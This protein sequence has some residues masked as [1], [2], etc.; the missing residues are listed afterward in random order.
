MSG[1]IDRLRT[2]LLPALV[3]AA[4]VALVTAGLL[5]WAGPTA[6]GAGPPAAPT[7]PSSPDAASASPSSIA[8]ASTA[9]WPSS[10][11]QPSPTTLGVASRVVIP[12]LRVDLPV[13]ASPPN[14]TFPLC[15][16]A[17]YSPQY[18]QPGQPG[19]T[20][21][22]A[23][24]RTGMFLPLLE[25]SWVDNGKAMIGDLVEV[26][27][28]ADRLYLYEISAVDR[29]QSSLP[30]GPTDGGAQGQLMLQTSE[31]PRKGLPGY[32]GLVLV[33]LAKPL[34][35]IPADHATANPTPHPL[36]CG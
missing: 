5:A 21:I 11:R 12:A 24:A 8:P 34:S 25:A 16:V 14:E 32:T 15:D 27:T 23:H 2:R 17:E 20:F 6:G 28:S 10:S 29:H 1:L 18:A 4:G 3:T 7:A 35:S 13:V 19:T 36:V 26:Y 33:L 22:Y 31:G 9:P 30:Y